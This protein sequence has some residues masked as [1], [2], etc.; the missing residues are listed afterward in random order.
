M[1]VKVRLVGD[2]HR[3]TGSRVVE[4]KAADQT[5]GAVIAA[6]VQEYPKLGEQ[7]FDEQGRIRYTW[8][9]VADGRPL[10][11][12]QDKEHRLQEDGELVIMRFFSGG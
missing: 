10:S 2:L 5:L 1:A 9:L 7:L 11:W 3:L 8:L 12:P 6:L 4:V